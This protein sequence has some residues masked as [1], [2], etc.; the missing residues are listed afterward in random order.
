MFSPQHEERNANAR[1][2]DSATGR[3]IAPSHS[4]QDDTAG[5]M[6]DVD[7]FRAFVKAGQ[8][9]AEIH[10]HY[11]QQPEF[12]LI[13]KEK[14][15]EKLDYRVQKMKLS[16]DKTA[17]IYNRFLTLSGIPK[18]AYEYRLGN[19]SALEWIID[20]YQ[21]STDK[22]SGITNDPNREEDQEYILRLIGKVVNISLET[23]KIVNSLPELNTAEVN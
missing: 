23:V 22:R 19:R 5:K 2:F 10:V 1:S 17:L 14:E 18:E 11:E 3:A 13:K 20:Q 7:V 9:L 8:R 4:A 6:S 21:V 16:K 12:P 15:G